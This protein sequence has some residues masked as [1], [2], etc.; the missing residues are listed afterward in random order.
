MI[1]YLLKNMPKRF[2][3]LLAIIC[4]TLITAQ[5]QCV[6]II[7][8]P[9]TIIAC[10]NA[11]VQFNP[12][13]TSAGL[14]AT[15]DT[16]W[17][18]TTGLSNPNIINPSATMGSASQ[19]YTLTIQALTPNNFVVNGDFSAGNTG[20]TSAYGPG[21]GGT[22]GL[23]SNPNTYAVTT[24]PSV[25]HTNF[26]NF[27][28]HTTGTG[29]MM[30][31]N[32][33]SIANT[34]VWCQTITVIPNSFYDFSA[35]ATSVDPGSPAILQFNIDGVLL[36]S[37]FNLS[38]T[39]GAW[40]QFH[41][42]WYSGTSTSITICIVNQN[43]ASGG[44][45]FAIDDIQFRQFCTTSKSCYV[46]VPNLTTSVVKTLGLGCLKDTVNFTTTN[47]GE[48]PEQY[49]WDFGDGTGDTV[50]NPSHVYLNQGNYSITLIVKK[51]GCTDTV[52]TTVNT[53]HP[54]APGFTT[55]K[56]TVCTGTAIT[57]TTTAIGANN[58]YNYDFGDGSF[59]TANSPSHTYATPGTYTIIQYVTDNIPCVDSFKK[60]VV[61]LPGPTGAATIDTTLICEGGA[62]NVDGNASI[63]YSLLTW[64]FGDGIKVYNTS[65]VKHAYDTSG[66]FTLTLTADYAVCPSVN[67]TLTVTVL[68]TP[69]VDLGADTTICENGT[70]IAL[71][72]KATNLMPTN[73][74]WY[75]STSDN[76]KIIKHPGIYWMQVSNSLG[77]A[78]A[79]SVEI[80]KSC[81]IDLP[82]SFT[83]N[84]DGINDFFFPRILNAKNLSYFSMQIFNRWGQLLFETKKLDG[85]GWDGKFNNTMQPVGVYIYNIEATVD[86]KNIEKYQGNISLLR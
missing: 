59:S 76:F 44:N 27:G 30:V 8:L 42:T 35:W 85:A 32:G 46:R 61:I 20:F 70:P 18:P 10:K 39:S 68:P 45:D 16:T 37:A 22:W 40:Q 48:T 64:D 51:L 54:F 71:I 79:D 60:T 38:A 50:Q 69:L 13:V 14:L 26:G 63:G 28:D 65:Q 57:C 72:N 4:S 86:G 55:D 41:A 84:G 15:S 7:G 19:L 67:T 36:G 24:N 62:V 34:S 66:V 3:S 2:L 83:P 1:K 81:Y 5:A 31:C 9:D 17:S 80:H 77:C 21:T 43:T 25:V 47:L 75:D 49:I 33:S 6:S 58:T 53:F 78:N 73:S 56:D 29:Q 23:L 52:K 11:K 74:I 12:S 82:N